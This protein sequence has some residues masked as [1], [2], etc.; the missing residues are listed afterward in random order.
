M[1]LIITLYLIGKLIC[2]FYQHL[3][4]FHELIFGMLIG[5]YTV[6]LAE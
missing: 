1:P 4:N 2:A 5:G 3:G 6:Y